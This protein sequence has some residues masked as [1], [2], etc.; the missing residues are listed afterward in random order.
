MRASGHAPRPAVDAAGLRGERQAVTTKR[1]GF[2]AGNLRRSARRVCHWSVKRAPWWQHERD[3]KA[4]D[5]LL[6]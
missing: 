5:D 4:R 1:G 3:Q 6:V 2:V